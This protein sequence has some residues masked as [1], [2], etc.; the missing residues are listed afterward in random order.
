[1]K[2]IDT[3]NINKELLI[4]E[5][6]I[7]ANIINEEFSKFLHSNISWMRK[8]PVLPKFLI[9]GMNYYNAIPANLRPVSYEEG[10]TL[11]EYVWDGRNNNYENSLLRASSNI[12][13]LI[14]F[15]EYNYKEESE[16]RKLTIKYYNQMLLNK[17][18]DNDEESLRMQLWHK[19]SD[20]KVSEYRFQITEKN[21]T[22]EI[23]KLI[24]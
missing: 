2:K 10:R 21:F 20:D 5:L 8:H 23:I 7:V 11:C 24:S 17:Y 15:I 12:W 16:L 13:A 3:T 1:M 14:E 19:A 22:N 6:D 9:E 4:E 18:E